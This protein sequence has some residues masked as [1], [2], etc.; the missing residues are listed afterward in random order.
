MWTPS[1][2]VDYYQN[3][4]ASWYRI[5]NAIEG[6]PTEVAIYDAIGEYGVTAK[7][8]LGELS[9]IK[10]PLDLHLS[11][12]GGEV[13]DGLLIYDALRQRGNVTVYVDSLA[14]SIASVIAQAGVRRIMA[15]NATMMIHD[16]STGAFG[17]ARDLAK[18]VDLLDKTSDNIADV[19]AERSG[20]DSTAWRTAMQAETWYRAQEAVDAGLADEIRGAAPVTNRVPAPPKIPEGAEPARP[21]DTPPAKSTIDLSHISAALEALK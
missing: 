13:F 2:V 18:M 7:D 21:D 8:F 11:S 15:P 9:D 5:K 10:G 17:N 3:G 16:A 4:R 1:Q 20:T 12:E 19:Y 6:L 14:A